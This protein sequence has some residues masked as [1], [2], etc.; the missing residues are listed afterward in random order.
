[1]LLL[2]VEDLARVGETVLRSFLGLPDLHLERRNVGKR[3]Y[4]AAS[5]GEVTR[6]LRLP[7]PLLD[8]IYGSRLARHFYSDQEIA[9][10]RERWSAKTAGGVRAPAR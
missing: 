8:Q 2:R 4:Y 7:E 6:S 5:Y 1:V 10:F 9:A 3:K